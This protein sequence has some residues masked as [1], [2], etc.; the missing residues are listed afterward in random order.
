MTEQPK[1]V[2]HFIDGSFVDSVDG[3]TFESISPID[4]AVIAHVAEGSSTDADRAVEAARRAFD[5]GPWPRISPAAR[6]A[7]IHRAADI[8]EARL[9]ELAAWETRD[10]GKPI[11]ESRT[12]VRTAHR[13]QLP[14]LR[15]L[16]RAGA[17]RGVPQAVGQR[18]HL[19][20]A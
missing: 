7:I 12:K 15:R 17:H 5:E 11:A 1:A 19:H 8:I 20:A 3:A 13:A 14:L 4:N 18:P 6:R 2:Q 16:R 9:D 10:M